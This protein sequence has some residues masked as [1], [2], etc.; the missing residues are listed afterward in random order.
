M[1]EEKNIR[2]MLNKIRSAKE[3][4]GAPSEL[5][6]SESVHR[7]QN[8]CERFRA[9][10]EDAMHGDEGE[11]IDVDGDDA[12]KAI[13]ISPKDVQFGT[14]RASQEDALKKTVGDVALKDDALK[15]FVDIKDI[16][17]NGEVSGLGLT[18]QFRYKDPSGDGCY[19]WADGLQLTE[20]NLKTVQKIRDAFANWKQSLVED[21]DLLQKLEKE[22]SRKA[23]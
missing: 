22:A 20:A 19:I 18:F 11:A 15:Y 6:I 23:Q 16:A 5:P 2:G 12:G 1:S 7:E 4:F 10:M 17:L 9:L 13:V 21:G 14:V 8:M 3:K